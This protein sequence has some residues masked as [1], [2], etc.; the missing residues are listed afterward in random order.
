MIG[1]VPDRPAADAVEER[2]SEVLLEAGDGL[3]Q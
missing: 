2:D 3:G 1:R